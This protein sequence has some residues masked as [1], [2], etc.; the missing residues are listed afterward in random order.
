MKSNVDVPGWTWGAGVAVGVC[1]GFAAAVVSCFMVWRS[2]ASDMAW[3]DWFP[4]PLAPCSDI[5][6]ETAEVEQE[7]LFAGGELRVFYYR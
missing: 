3:K 5:A 1:D 6:E 2:C 4:E 7:G